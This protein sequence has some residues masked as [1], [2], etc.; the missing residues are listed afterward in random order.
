MANDNT[1][2]T[3]V[4]IVLL[5]YFFMQPGA[6]DT[7]KDGDST[8]IGDGKGSSG[9]TAGCGNVEDVLFKWNDFNSYKLGTD[10]ASALF[11]LTGSGVAPQ[12]VADDASITV[13]V[14]ALIRGIAGEDSTTYFSELYE[15]NVGCSDPFTASK[16]VQLE[17]A[18]APTITVVNDDGTT[19]NADTDAGRE[20]VA[21]SNSYVAEFTVRAP[22]DKCSSKYGTIFAC[23]Y[24]ATYIQIVEAESNIDQ[25]GA[26]IYRTQASH[27]NATYDQW[28][29]FEYPGELCDGAKDTFALKYTTTSTTPTDNAASLNCSWFPK[30]YD[31]D[32]DTYDVIGPSIYDED[33]NLISL[34]AN[35]EAVVFNE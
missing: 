18:G 25:V 21:A 9:N 29:T 19:K 24:D 6:D 4:V 27:G 20:D 33:N 2:I 34:L 26:A 23:Q 16:N 1:L 3:V 28:A 31:K 14:N 12:S 13:P 30:D 17:Q 32:E 22:A 15:E 8:G 5:G 35:T 10:P 11:I 7:T